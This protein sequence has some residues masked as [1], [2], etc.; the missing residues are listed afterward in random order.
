MDKICPLP[1]IDNLIINLLHI[2]SLIQLSRTNKFIHNK[3]S[4]S[5]AYIS[6]KQF[7]LDLTRTNHYFFVFE[8]YFLT[9]CRQGKLEI[10]RYLSEKYNLSR[11]LKLGYE[12]ILRTNNMPIIQQ[13]SREFGSAKPASLNPDIKWILWPDTFDFFFVFGL[14]NLPCTKENFEKALNY[15]NLD[16]LTYIYSHNKFTNIEIYC[17]IRDRIT[18]GRLKWLINNCKIDLTINKYIGQQQPYIWLYY[19]SKYNGAIYLNPTDQFLIIFGK[20]ILEDGNPE[21]LA[22]LI[23]IKNQIDQ[24]IIYSYAFKAKIWRQS[25]L[26]CYL[27]QYFLTDNSILTSLWYYPF[28]KP[29][30][31]EWFFEKITEGLIGKIFEDPIIIE[32]SVN[33][34]LTEKLIL[35]N[36]MSKS[37]LAEHILSSAA[38]A[39][40]H[41]LVKYILDNSKLDFSKIRYYLN[42]SIITDAKTVEILLEYG[43]LDS[44][45]I[46]KIFV[47]HINQGYI[48]Q[49]ELLTIVLSEIKKNGYK[50]EID[51][52]Y[53][54]RLASTVSKKQAQLVY[55]YYKKFIHLDK[56]KI[57]WLGI[58]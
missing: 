58:V 27:T 56:N 33:K 4:N 43:L 23:P 57:I 31:S 47:E 42:N 34:N 10:I 25:N 12:E 1:D 36:K 52:N 44:A 40:N 16:L 22:E 18:P 29:E 11:L 3:I 8:K 9:A 37:I 45:Y 38:N 54:F 30:V 15:E 2:G 46:K 32:L 24:D 48:Y 28:S 6:A 7:Y 26:L 17:L 14:D 50:L 55:D 41:L 35:K 39:G 51:I 21:L 19:N 20:I 5:P 13:Y 53:L 49:T